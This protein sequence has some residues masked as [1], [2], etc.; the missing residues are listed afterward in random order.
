MAVGGAGR[1]R[2]EQPI[3]AACGDDENQHRLATMRFRHE[4]MLEL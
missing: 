4:D 3:D 1:C 2:Y